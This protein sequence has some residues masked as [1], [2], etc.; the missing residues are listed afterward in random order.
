MSRHQGARRPG[1]NKFSAKKT[2]CAHGHMHASK[3]EALRCNDLHILQRA[4]QI[5]DLKQQ[6]KFRCAFFLAFFPDLELR[7]V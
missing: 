6:P 1:T 4:G 5:S 2:A 7:E 3:R